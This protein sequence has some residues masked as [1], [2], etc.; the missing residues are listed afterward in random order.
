MA[1]RG[2]FRFQNVDS[3]KDLND[4]F[5]GLVLKGVLDPGATH[6]SGAGAVTTPV[7]FRVP[8]QLAV[9]VRGFMAVGSDGMVCVHDVPPNTI[10]GLRPNATT[11]IVLRSIYQSA[12]PADMGFE[13]LSTAEFDALVTSD[14]AKR[15]I[16]AKVT[17]GPSDV[18]DD[19]GI[20]LRENDIVD[21]FDRYFVRGV[22][23]TFDDLPVDSPTSVQRVKNGDTYLVIDD[24]QFYRW[25]QLSG[26]WETVTDQAVYTQLKLH[27]GVNGP[28]PA[29]SGTATVAYGSNN[30]TGDSTAF[31]TELEPGDIIR[32][33]NELVTYEVDSISTNLLLVLTMPYEGNNASGKLMTK[34]V[35]NAEN[36]GGQP[37]VRDEQGFPSHPAAAIAYTPAGGGFVAATNVQDALTEIDAEKVKKAGDSM[38][39]QLS[40]SV[41]GLTESLVINSENGIAVVSSGTSI[42]NPS[43]SFGIYSDGARFAVR[44]STGESGTVNAGA[45]GVLGESYNGAENASAVHGIYSGAYNG[46]TTLQ[47]AVLGDASSAS[48]TGTVYGVKAVGKSGSP[49]LFADANGNGIAVLGLGSGTKQGVVGI[50]GGAALTVLDPLDSTY[51]KAGVLGLGSASGEGVIGLG[52]SS[53]GGSGGTFTGGSGGGIG[54]TATGTLGYSGVVATGGTST[55]QT[56]GIGVLGIGGGSHAVGVVARGGGL[57]VA[58]PAGALA[59]GVFATGGTT[60]G[61]GVHAIG[62]GNGHGGVFKG[63]SGGGNGAQ[64]F[65]TGTGGWSGLTAKGGDNGGAGITAQGGDTGAS[66]GGVFEGGTLGGLGVSGTGTGPYPGIYAAASGTGS[67]AWVERTNTSYSALK[68]TGSWSVFDGPTSGLSKPLVQVLQG[69]TTYDAENEVEALS[70]GLYVK[71]IDGPAVVAYSTNKDEVTALIRGANASSGEGGRGIFVAGGNGTNAHGGLGIYVSG[72]SATGSSKNGGVAI[73]A[74]GGESESASG[75]TAITAT[76]GESASGNSAHGIV[77]TGGSGGNGNG[78]GG[79]FTGGSD[80]GRGLTATGKA[81]YSGVYANGGD[82]KVGATTANGGNGVTAIGGTGIG[83]EYNGGHGI[84][85]TAGSGTSSARK[86]AAIVATG[87]IWWKDGG[88]ILLTGA[89]DD[90]FNLTTTSTNLR[91][92]GSPSYPSGGVGISFD[93]SD[94]PKQTTVTIYGDCP[95]LYEMT[96]TL[97][98]KRIADGATSIIAGCTT[99]APIPSSTT[100][101]TANDVAFG[102]GNFITISKTFI[103]RVYPESTSVFSIY[104]LATVNDK[105]QYEAGYSLEVNSTTYSTPSTWEIKRIPDYAHSELVSP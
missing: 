54:V 67:A 26:E 82:Y 9:E 74:I 16:L 18:V 1:L 28:S 58:I 76:G 90:R 80:G 78:Q 23:Q 98:F 59:A 31:T 25:D 10:L 11:Y 99:G 39:G 22:V 89:A 103:V 17:T 57:T 21:K 100:I 44:G 96:Y 60:N 46:T 85:A 33:G 49:A 102:T 55:S 48:G 42:G 45:A 56:D 43:G 20:D 94:S 41:T 3:T 69:S 65:G 62:G 81:G 93:D 15:I 61:N 37:I 97:L 40:I 30:V 70:A 32:F 84:D 95:G 24:R 12:G 14:K 71:A 13:T 6:Q 75:G 101:F 38:T 72:G 52:G 88:R 63:G 83:Y 51:E 34:V 8:G 86:G 50:G 66:H 79:V 2:I 104:A 36:D 5:G 4:R 35:L 29:L 92:N 105:F 68:V 53:A 7:V 87:S 27:R 19:G 73:T 64:F 47:S 91:F 77:A